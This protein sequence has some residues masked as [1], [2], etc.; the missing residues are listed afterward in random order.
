M[1]DLATA[2]AVREDLTRG[3]RALMVTGAILALAKL[4]RRRFRRQARWLLHNGGTSLNLYPEDLK[5][6]A[7]ME[8]ILTTTTH[9]GWGLAAAELGLNYATSM[10][11]PALF[12]SGIDRTT[13]ERL[14]KD[15][16]VKAFADISERSSMIALTEVGRAFNAGALAMAAMG[17]DVEKLWVVNAEA[18]PACLALA[19]EG[20]IP[21]SAPFLS[22]TWAPPLH[23]NCACSLSFRSVNNPVD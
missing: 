10:T 21:Q 20:Y 18:C 1:T 8:R 4:L 3:A 22:G 2:I 7:E 15:G 16:I 5:T 9:D 14:A 13:E 11:M 6:Q 19:S 12:L 17:Q 23:P